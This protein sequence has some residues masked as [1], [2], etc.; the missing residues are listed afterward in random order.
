MET[1]PAIAKLLPAM[2]KRAALTETKR[3]KEYTAYLLRKWAWLATDECA[4]YLACSQEL[5]AR[6]HAGRKRKE[7][8]VAM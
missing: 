7:A 2:R 6:K 3:L 8:V 5:R 1:P 4:A